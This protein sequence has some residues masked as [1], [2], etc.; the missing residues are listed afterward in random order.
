MEKHTRDSVSELIFANWESDLPDRVLEALRPLDG[1]PITTRILAKMP[2]LPESDGWR[3]RREYGMT[4]LQTLSYL[5]SDFRAKHAISLLLAHS[6]ASVPLDCTYVVERNTAY[7][8]ARVRRNHARME[9]RNDREL[10]DV[11]AVVMNE[12]EI[13]I[14]RLHRVAE[15]FTK[16]TEYGTVLDPDRYTLARA[17]GLMDSDGRPFIN[18][19]YTTRATEPVTG[20]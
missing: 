17:C 16:L 14:D 20:E 12:I 18:P 11:T 1:K 10:L 5:R 3:L 15:H 13:A 2:A 7:F 9:A 6:E 4:H 8:E 19:Q